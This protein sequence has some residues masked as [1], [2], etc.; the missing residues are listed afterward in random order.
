MYKSGYRRLLRSVN[1]AFSQDLRAVKMA[2]VKLREEFYQ[3][4]NVK[5]INHLKQLAK[6]IDDVDEML[7]FHIV[8]GKRTVPSCAE[9]Q[10]G[11]SR[12]GGK[13]GEFI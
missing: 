4:R 12:D 2:R 9:A 3:N 13:F 1:F 11:S 6:D 10:K 5:D 8:Q 7:R